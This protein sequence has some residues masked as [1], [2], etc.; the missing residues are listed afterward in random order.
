MANTQTTRTAEQD[1]LFQRVQKDFDRD[2]RTHKPWVD[3]IDRRYRAYR[4]VLEE[5]SM[6]ASFT[7]KQHPAYV[8]QSIETMV[9]NL[10]DPSPK[11]RLRAR[12]II[13]TDDDIKRLRA[14][15]KANELLLDHQLTIDHYAE[16]QRVFDLQGLITGTTAKKQMWFEKVTNRRFQKVDQMPV[17]DPQ[18]NVIGEVPKY[19]VGAAEYSVRDDPTSEVVDVRGLVFPENATAMDRLDRIHHVMWY[20]FDELKELEAAAHYGTD[21]GGEP[22]DLLKD[23]KDFSSDL[24]NREKDL[25]DVKRTKDL[26]MVVEH[27]VDRGQRVVTTA[28]QKV[29][30]ANKPNPFWFDHLDHPFPFVI[31][32]SMPDLFRIQGISEVELMAELQEMLWT[33]TNQRLDSTQLLANA[34]FLIA[35]DV[36]DPDAFEFAPGE[37]WLVPRPVT[38]TV[39]PWS[40]DPSVPQMT[41]AAE[42]N[43]KGDLQ[44]IT[45]GMPFV[46]GID[47]A[48]LQGG[49]ATSVSIVTTLAQKR[50]AA[51]KQQF[52][53]ANGR[54]GEQWCALN[55]QFIRAPRLVPVVG[56]EGAEDFFEIRPEMLQ[57]VYLFETEMAD[58]S[59]IRQERLAETQARLQTASNVVGIFAQ[60]SGVTGGQVPALNMRAFMDDYLEAGGVS[61][62]DRYYL[63]EPVPAQ[64][65]QQPAQPATPG[66]DTSGTTNTALAAGPTAPSNDTSMSP[67]VFAQ[68]AN[69]RAN[70]VVNI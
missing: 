36:E 46:A 2:M 40:P 17:H 32:S 68:Q 16:K 18:G 67:G 29:M 69:A 4:G 44:N 59:L 48:A 24:Y 27:W 42:A 28:N 5:R 3:K 25:F 43:V 62:K 12:P 19:T 61:D 22:V 15:A 53:W 63:A 54:V 49:T 41:L 34:I 1:S 7:N 45:G 23:S 10:I 37:R 9:A 52:V 14:G 26:I 66:Q 55:Q 31:C 11:W 38:E 39:K 47:Q 50:L 30:L 20:S 35:D 51:K 58:E 60:L 33:L 65:L 21:A 13:G 56:R 8:L 57:G 6:A 70:G 64:G